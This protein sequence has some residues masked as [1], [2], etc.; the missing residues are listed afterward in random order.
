M[1]L[2]LLIVLV[3]VATLICISKLWN[4]NIGMFLLINPLYDAL[5]ILLMM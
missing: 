1:R 3:I 5:N 2:L 4:I